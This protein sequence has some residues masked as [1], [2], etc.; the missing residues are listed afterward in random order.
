M[1]SWSSQSSLWLT[2][3]NTTW[4][5]CQSMHLMSLVSLTSILSACEGSWTPRTQFAK[6]SLQ[7]ER[8]QNNK[9]EMQSAWTMVKEQREKG[10][11]RSCMHDLLLP[12]S[13]CSLTIVHADCISGLLFWAR[14]FCKECFAN[15]VRGVHEPSQALNMLVRLTRLMRCMLWQHSQVVFLV[16]NH[17]E[18]W[19]LHEFMR[20][21]MCLHYEYTLTTVCDKLTNICDNCPEGSLRSTQWLD[22]HNSTFD[23]P[24]VR[25]LCKSQSILCNLP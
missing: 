1:N 8:A 24:F 17:R 12:F 18:L 13:R 16:V 6:H 4:E 7:K 25:L 20:L 22:N 19:E 3:K 9:P 2:T 15:C 21:T 5:C 11:N 23:K 10:N 14:S